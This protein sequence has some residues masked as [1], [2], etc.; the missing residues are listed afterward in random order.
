MDQDP[1]E[2]EPFQQ[3]IMLENLGYSLK[4]VHE[5]VTDPFAP[6]PLDSRNLTIRSK[7]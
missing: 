3:Q 5:A 2:I 6:P 1:S 4:S 7:Q